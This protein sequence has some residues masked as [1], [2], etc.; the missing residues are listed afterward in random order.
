MEVNNAVL[1]LIIKECCRS[2]SYNDEERQFSFSLRP[3]L[4]RVWESNKKAIWSI[5]PDFMLN[6]FNSVLSNLELQADTQNKIPASVL[7]D[8][9]IVNGEVL[10]IEIYGED[11]PLKLI[12]M[13]RGQYLNVL[14]GM[15]LSFGD[16]F[17]F[18][19]DRNIVTSEGFNQGVCK[20]I[21]ILLPSAYHIVLSRVFLGKYFL[22][23]IGSSLWPI[24]DEAKEYIDTHDSKH[25]DYI[26]T[27][28]TKLGIGSFALLNILKSVCALTK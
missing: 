27:I 2:L 20:S 28:S 10:S 1:K 22:N 8:N 25:L 17:E 7:K 19:V 18:S 12:K 21:S 6:D 11:M 9:D 13:K 23:N 15:G 3:S 14:S 5:H 26:M 4:H 24:F 16:K